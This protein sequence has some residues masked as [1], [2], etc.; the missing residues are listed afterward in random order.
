MTLCYSQTCN[1][2]CLTGF[3]DQDFC[4]YKVMLMQLMFSLW[5]L[6][7]VVGEKAADLSVPIVK[8]P[9]M[10]AVPFLLSCMR[11]GVAGVSITCLYSTGTPLHTVKD[12]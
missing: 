7:A 1:G 8:S 10:W 5:L 12:K 6:G 9:L 4:R 11:S 2:W 3:R